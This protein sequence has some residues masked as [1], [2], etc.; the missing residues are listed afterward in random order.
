M[1]KTISIFL[2]FLLVFYSL[3]FSWALALEAPEAPTP[4]PVE[5]TPPPP[6][7]VPNSSKL[8]GE[9]QPTS[10]PEPTPTLST[11]SEVIDLT[12]STNKSQSADEQMNEATVAT[13]DLS[14]EAG[15]TAGENLNN[16][17]QSASPA[18]KENS[19]TN[20]E[21]QAVINQGLEQS[22]TTGGNSVS[23]NVGDSVINTGE[24]NASAE[25]INAVNTNLSGV[26]VKEI[27]VAGDHQGD[28]LLD[29]N[30]DFSKASDSAELKNS[31]SEAF[32]TNEATLENNLT[33]SA[34]TGGNQAS[35]NTGGDSSIQT[36]NAHV[37]AAVANLVNNNLA[38]NVLLG[39]VNIFGNLTGDIVV[40]S[41]ALSSLDSSSPTVFTNLSDFSETFQT[42]N[43]Q[44]EN[45][46]ILEANTGE[47]EANYNTGGA[48]T[49]ES[50]QAT[51]L[52]QTVNVVN[53][54]LESGDWWLVIINQAGEWLGRIMGV[55]E[56]VT[57][58]ASENAQLTVD[59]NGEVTMGSAG[60]NQTQSQS[61][62]QNN[63]AKL[64]NNLNLKANTGR[65]QANGNTG[66]DNIIKTGEAKIILNLINFVNNNISSKSRLVVTVVNVF[67]R[68]IGNFLPPGAT[69]PVPGE[70][71]QQNEPDSEENLPNNSSD[72]DETQ[73]EE[74]PVE[75]S[76]EITDEIEETNYP[77]TI[78]EALVL[79]E[80]RSSRSFG[81]PNQT[82]SQPEEVE[83]LSAQ[84]AEGLSSLPKPFKIN[85]AWLTILLPVL[86]LSV[87]LRRL[88]FY[89]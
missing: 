82:E 64:V 45:N 29:F 81:T 78:N 4:P 38:G 19:Q 28:I 41:E 32:Q 16:L 58:A 88:I 30:S 62:E 74:K 79:G 67:G 69:K 11:A 18:I 1:K 21:N 73:F 46:L 47:N 83:T 52:V 35:L 55:P 24:A 22:I 27:N 49:I 70:T 80:T 8:S 15:S 31:S 59:E 85:L 56:G 60:T 54:N 2:A 12:D 43:A 26:A 36:G 44:I 89:H 39:I 72:S 33:L 57:C 66:G 63:E 51:A 53:N 5:V 50:G 17:S 48:S 61:T 13:G 34:N 75:T 9:L 65:N 23:L 25:V 10:T 14:T 6:P 76:G 68:W 87:V 40:P 7:E 42:N 86:F 77:M 37:E 3:G 71:N 84:A 20:Q